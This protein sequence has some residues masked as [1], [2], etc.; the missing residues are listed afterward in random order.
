M[1]RIVG[2]AI[3]EKDLVLYCSRKRYYAILGGMLGALFI[4]FIIHVVAFGGDLSVATGEMRRFGFTFF[5]YQAIL[6]LLLGPFFAASA[7][8]GEKDKNCLGLLY[9]TS[10]GRTGIVVGKFLSRFLLL[11]LFALACLPL[12]LGCLF[13]GGIGPREIFIL[14]VLVTLM[15]LFAC[16]VGSFLSLV[17]RRTLV[18]AMLT[19]IIMAVLFAGDFNLRTGARFWEGSKWNLWVNPVNA[20]NQLMLDREFTEYWKPMIGIPILVGILIVIS[21][22]ILPFYF[23][24]GLSRVKKGLLWL[25]EKTA[26]SYR[27]T[28]HVWN[29]PI[30]WRYTRGFLGQT[31]VVVMTFVATFLVYVGIAALFLDEMLLLDDRIILC[32][33]LYGVFVLTTLLASTVLAGEKENGTLPLLLVTPMT[34]RQFIIGKVKGIIRTSGPVMLLPMIHVILLA[35]FGIIHGGYALLFIVLAVV[36]YFFFL[37]QGLYI[38]LRQDTARRATMISLIVIVIE[39][40]FF[41]LFPFLNPILLTR[42]MVLSQ[43]EM[44]GGRSGDLLVPGS[45]LSISFLCL[46]VL[47]LCLFYF[48]SVKWFNT[49]IDRGD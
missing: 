12:A 37:G 5:A 45:I 25:Q 2:S 13:I 48:E 14:F 38:S 27:A 1:D 39:N 44:S 43:A 8:I 41:F 34:G 31:R 10:L 30:Y 28:E 47:V 17:M 21:Y 49:F 42:F 19:Y 6:M 40:I 22:I 11:E 36:A 32:I 35:F 26:N 24:E 23:G 16:A 33:A 7:F 3:L 18:A 15:N 4:A 9:L 20:F 29:D 46:E